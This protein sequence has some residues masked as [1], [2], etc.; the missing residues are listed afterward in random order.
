MS[1]YPGRATLSGHAAR[2]P[3]PAGARYHADV[4]LP[5]T[6]VNTC[7]AWAGAV[8]GWVGGQVKSSVPMMGKAVTVGRISSSCNAA[9]NRRRR[10]LVAC[11]ERE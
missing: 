6:L 9:S 3:L 4:T 2:C 5:T 11:A 7:S 8:R 10:S 1:R